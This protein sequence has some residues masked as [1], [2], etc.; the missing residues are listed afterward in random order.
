MPVKLV[1]SNTTIS[2]ETAGSIGTVGGFFTVGQNTD[3]YGITNFHVVQKNGTATV[4]D[5]VYDSSMLY[6]IG[7][8]ESW[9]KL[10]QTLNYFDLALFKVDM[11]AVLPKWNRK[12]GGFADACYVNHVELHK[13][14][15]VQYGICQGI[16]DGPFTMILDGCA[17]QFGNLLRI[18]S[19]S[20]GTRFSTRGDS[21][22]ILMSDDKI[23]ALLIGADP[24][25][26]TVSY[27]IPFI[28]SV[29]KKGILHYLKLVP[30][31]N[32]I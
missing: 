2:P 31:H 10:N 17:Y 27:A 13:G 9:Y 20:Y 15:A 26:Y 14:N 8:L 24:N 16:S 18:Q 11:T 1:M 25:D 21:G 7:E 5:P 22:S 3:V 32:S 6:Q 28:D 12:V 23:V 19:A 29:K 4:N 30:S